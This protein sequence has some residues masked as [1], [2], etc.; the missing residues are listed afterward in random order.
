[1]SRQSIDFS[2]DDET[3]IKGRELVP[4][5]VPK[6]IMMSS[7]RFFFLSPSLTILD[8]LSSTVGKH[9]SQREESQ[10]NKM[11]TKKTK[12]DRK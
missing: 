9:A 1:M 8:P 7:A 11:T 2:S 6:R 5:S 3:K 10:G 4:P 12:G